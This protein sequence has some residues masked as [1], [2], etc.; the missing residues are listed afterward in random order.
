MLCS[1]YDCSKRITVLPPKG[2]LELKLHVVSAWKMKA[3]KLHAT[4]CVL[5]SSYCL[6]WNWATPLKC[7]MDINGE[8]G[9]G[10]Q[11]LHPRYSRHF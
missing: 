2:Q 8:A 3:E 11:A 5:A 9:S 6:Y 7:F 1:I 4:E 10:D